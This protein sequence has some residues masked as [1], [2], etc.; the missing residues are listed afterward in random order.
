MDH[1]PA[2][3]TD[4][5]GELAR[6]RDAAARLAWAQAYQSL[7]LAHRDG[8][9]AAAD[10]ELLATAS[11]LVGQ[12]ADCLQAMQ[13]A[14]QAYLGAGQPRRAARLLFWLGFILLQQGAVA[15][16]GGWLA[17]AGRLLENEPAECAEHGLLLLAQVIQA[18]GQGD[19]GG[20]ADLAARIVEIGTAVPDAEVQS[21]GLHWQGR[22]M[23]RQGRLAEG[24]RMLDESMTAVVAEEVAPYVAGAIYC[25]MID[26]CRE[27]WD[28]PRGR[29]WTA[30]L[31]TWCDRQPDMFT[32]SG[33][34]MVHRAELMQLS[35][36]WAEAAAEAQR[37]CDRFAYAADQYA[38][39]AAWYRLAEVHRVQGAAPQA[40][41]AYRLGGEWGHDP[42]P[43]LALLWLAEGRIA[44]ARAAVD[45]AVAETTDRLRR[46]LLLPAQVEIALAAGDLAVARSAADELAAIAADYATPVLQAEADRAR[47]AVLLA[48]GQAHRALGAL[49]AAWQ[50]WRELEAPYEA[51]R[52]R[53]MIGLGCRALG[54]AESAALELDSARRVFERL[55]AAPDLARL[56]A[57]IRPSPE[58][59]A[60]THGLTSREL[61]V[62]RLLAAGRTNRMIAA[63]LVLANKTVDRHV[64]NIFAK[65][66]VSSRA[67]ATA[68][69]YRHGVV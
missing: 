58:P 45:R 28:V 61:Q 64:S 68:Y 62:L 13:R 55:G 48:A 18:T 40:A 25:S 36:Q 52:V 6:G 20:A 35:G 2:A 46:V 26:A 69:A 42:Q 12:V 47:G 19:H 54:D 59:V 21:L 5:A 31:S 11:Y 56:D 29:E 66:R 51:A 39:G 34:C 37:A 53:E 15:Q 8:A 3:V 33:Q 30:A 22:A 16:G 67:A 9:L 17:R 10:L 57:R 41:E 27:V 50:V 63:E 44:A 60:A 43:G 14:H 7:T 4:Q 32:F 23:L 49:R 24:L 38:T 65:L 1:P